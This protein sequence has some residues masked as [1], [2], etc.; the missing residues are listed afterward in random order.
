MSKIKY[1]FKRILKMNYKKFFDTINLVHKRSNKNRIYIFFDIIICGLK[2]QAGYM[3]YNLFEMYNMNSKERKTII[4]RGINNSFIKKYNDQSQIYKFEDK[5]EFN[6]IFDKYLNREWLY[7][8][9]ASLEDFKKYIKGKTEII[10]KPIDS[11]CGTGIEIID[12]RKKDAKELYDTLIK[13]GQL[14]VEDVV[15]QN[16]EISD[17]YPHSVNTL[18]VVTINKKVVAAYLRIGNKGNVVDN[19]NHGGMA[20]KVNIENGLIEYPAI[21]KES[22]VYDVHPE[23]KKAIVGVTVPMWDEVVKLC[24]EISHIIPEVG[25]VGWDICVGD[26]KLYLIEGNDFPG[27]DIY[28]LPVHRSDNYGDLPI[29][30]KAMRGDENENS[31]SN[32]S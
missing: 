2:Y 3:D 13:N 29:F 23:T 12:P 22:K 11:S 25:Y 17:I 24:E 28:Q 18:R 15:K 30:E 14:L 1:L 9:E 32:R 8:S 5:V 6:K 4:T 27:H 10:V 21:D 7:L 16:K 31:N 20:T 19:F 26:K